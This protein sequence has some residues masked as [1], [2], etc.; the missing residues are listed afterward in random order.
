MYDSTLKTIA[1]ISTLA[2]AGNTGIAV[3]GA[4]PEITAESGK[5]YVCGEVDSLTI[6]PPDTGV[7]DVLF[8]SGTTPTV[9]TIPDTVLFPEWFNPA[10]LDASTVYEIN[11]MDGIYGAVMTWTATASE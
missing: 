9:L 6:T 5:R 4:D 11:I 2:K 8:A 10:S 3:T 1:L 7:I